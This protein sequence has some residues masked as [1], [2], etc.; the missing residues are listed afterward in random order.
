MELKM[1]ESSAYLCYCGLNCK[2]CSLVATLPK[3]ARALFE[4]MQ[5]DGWEFYGQELFPQFPEFWAVLKELKQMDETTPLCKGGCGDPDCAIRK[6]AISKGLE[7]CAFCAEYPCE[8]LISFTRRYP[9]LLENNDRIKEIG[10]VAWLAEQDE[11]AARGITNKK[12]RE[13]HNKDGL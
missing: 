5:E 8:R 13:L 2:L 12:L 4:T 9:F 6:C 3:Q 1:K 10:V 7:V 11:L